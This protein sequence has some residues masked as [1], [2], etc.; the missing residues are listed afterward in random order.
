MESK[1]LVKGILPPPLDREFT[2]VGK[3]LNRRDGVEKVTGRAEYS[4]DMKLPNMLYAKI[5]RCPYPRA[6]ITRLETSKAEAL[7]GVKA[8][9]SKDNTAGWR[10]YWYTVPQ[11]AFPECITYE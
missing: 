5:L 8:V 4:G 6:R 7:P 3:P 11:L 10:T 2:I 1:L 9:L